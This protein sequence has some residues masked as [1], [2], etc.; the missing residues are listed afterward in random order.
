[1]L[2]RRT[3]SEGEV[4]NSLANVT[5]NDRRSGR[6]FHVGDDVDPLVAVAAGG[7]SRE[8]AFAANTD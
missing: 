5:L 2:P 8:W 3:Q 6:R 7:E 4:H 1:M